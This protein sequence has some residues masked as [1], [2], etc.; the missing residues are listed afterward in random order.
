M[1][2]KIDAETFAFDYNFFVDFYDFIDTSN[3]GRLEMNDKDPSFLSSKECSC[4]SDIGTFRKWPK[5]GQQ[6]I[7]LFELSVFKYKTLF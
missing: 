7:F 4:R 5:A 3:P 1:S 6:M 2:A